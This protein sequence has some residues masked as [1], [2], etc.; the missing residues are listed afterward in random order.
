M[1]VAF[2]FF[3]ALALIGTSRAQ[4]AV[5]RTF[6]PGHPDHN[7][8]DGLHGFEVGVTTQNMLLDDLRD[9]RPVLDAENSPPSTSGWQTFFQQ[10]YH[11]VPG[12]NNHTVAQINATDDGWMGVRVENIADDQ[13][14]TMELHWSLRYKPGCEVHVAHTDGDAW[15][16][17]DNY[18]HID[19]GGVH[20]SENVFPKTPLSHRGLS[21]DTAFKAVAFFAQRHALTRRSDNSAEWLLR[22]TCEVEDD[23]S[24]PKIHRLDAPLAMCRNNVGQ[25]QNGG[26][27][28][29]VDKTE[30]FI[31]GDAC[32]CRPGTCGPWCQ[33][34]KCLGHGISD[35]DGQCTCTR[36]WSGKECDVC[37]TGGVSPL[38]ARMAL[39]SPDDTDNTAVWSGHRHGH[40][41]FPENIVEF[42]MEDARQMVGVCAPQKEQGTDAYLYTTLPKQVMDMYLN[43][44]FVL[45]D[46]IPDEKLSMHGSSSGDVSM[47]MAATDVDGVTTLPTLPGTLNRVDGLYY[48][49]ECKAHNLTAVKIV[50][51]AQAVGITTVH[52]DD[53]VEYNA[54][55]PNSA[56]P[57]YE[58]ASGAAWNRTTCTSSHSIVRRYEK[59]I[60]MHSRH[61]ARLAIHSDLDAPCQNAPGWLMTVF[62][63]LSTNGVLLGVLVV[64]SGML[65]W[66][67]THPV[68][69]VGS[70][71]VRGVRSRMRFAAEVMLNKDLS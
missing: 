44:M 6:A 39:A 15:V 70:T 51:G 24:A 4:T 58:T 22:T 23:A 42:D 61:T 9:Q 71:F 69:D 21:T 52:V 29:F 26:A 55:G 30:R 46:S 19:G 62:A 36:G 68:V 40:V 60:D 10:W 54:L 17:V 59:E 41:T 18:L 35:D 67:N 11:T 3:S 27:C 57:H 49:C 28:I 53:M 25:C 45:L 50:H 1:V 8:P 16:F 37:S 5:V 65:Q 43:G 20:A 12:V 14:V 32:A 48:D 63:I 47:L 33:F 66:N 64:A 34:H 7:I 38:Q 2:V 31:D 13:M 56:L